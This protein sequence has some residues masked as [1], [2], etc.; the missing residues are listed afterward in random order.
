[1][2]WYRIKLN[3]DDVVAFKHGEIQNTFEKRF[4]DLG[5]PRDAA[6]FSSSLDDGFL[7]IYFSPGSLSFCKDIITAYSGEPCETP[8]RIGVGLLVGYHDALDLLRQDQSNCAD[9]S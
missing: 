5:G 6:L 3:T 8:G 7:Y 1:M 4:F 2:S 9:E